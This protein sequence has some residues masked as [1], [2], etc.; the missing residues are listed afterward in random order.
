MKQLKIIQ[1]AKFKYDDF[2]DQDGS[3]KSKVFIDYNY[4]HNNSSQATKESF[5]IQTCPEAFTLNSEMLNMTNDNETNLLQSNKKVPCKKIMS[6]NP[7]NK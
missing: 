4:V 5:Y 3:I 7:N 6:S 2:T 1:D